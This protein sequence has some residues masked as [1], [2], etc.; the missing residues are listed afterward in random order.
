VLADCHGR[1]VSTLP[2]LSPTITGRQSDPL[3]LLSWLFMPK[4]RA[5]ANADTSTT[6]RPAGF[7]TP[8]TLTTYPDRAQ[9]LTEMPKGNEHHALVVA[10]SW[11]QSR[12]DMRCN[13][14]ARTFS[15]WSIHCETLFQNFCKHR[16]MPVLA[17]R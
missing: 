14:P 9:L 2:S 11:L 5:A 1:T 17:S 7:Y 10:P 3:P 6:I 4:C 15:S 16:P 8:E 12:V 13:L